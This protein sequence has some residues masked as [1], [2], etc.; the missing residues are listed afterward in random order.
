MIFRV[1]DHQRLVV[2]SRDAREEIFILLFD[3]LFFVHGSISVF[4]LAKTPRSPSPDKIFFLK[5]LRPLGLCGRIPISSFRELCV[6][7]G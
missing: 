3:N 6:L 7:C 5:P 1:V 2:I 4:H